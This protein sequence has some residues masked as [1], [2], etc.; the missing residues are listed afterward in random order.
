MA[1]EILLSSETTDFIWLSWRDY[2]K[3]K[4][5]AHEAIE[6]FFFQRGMTGDEEVH[7]CRSYDTI[8]DC[9]SG[10]QETINKR[11]G[12]IGTITVVAGPTNDDV[13]ALAHT[14]DIG[15]EGENHVPLSGNKFWN[16]LT[17]EER[18]Q[19]LQEEGIEIE[20]HK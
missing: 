9:I 18:K 16:A 8:Q 5:V 4:G 2:L 14:A 3:Q 17:Q 6:A 12:E 20:D 11:R 10:I 15:Q 19:R 13:F 7:F 1:N